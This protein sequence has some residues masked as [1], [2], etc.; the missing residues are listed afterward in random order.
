VLE[1]LHL[2][3]LVGRDDEH[4][5]ERPGVDEPQVAALLE[6]EHD[7]GMRGQRDTPRSAVELPAHAEVHDEDL[8]RIERDGDV[9]AVA[10]DL[11]DLLAGQPRGELLA[12]LV[13]P[14]RAHRVLRLLHLGGLD[15]LADDVALEIAAHHLHLG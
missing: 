9:L 11:R 13:S 1:L 14:D 10:L 3:D 8:P 5:A 12:G 4:L 7:V 6:R 15:L 2:A